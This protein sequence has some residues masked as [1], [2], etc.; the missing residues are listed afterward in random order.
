MFPVLC[1]WFLNDCGKSDRKP[2]AESELQ[3]L[4]KL[5]P[6]LQSRGFTAVQGKK[7]SNTL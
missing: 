7:K 5:V 4:Q 6:H 1:L 3:K 2:L